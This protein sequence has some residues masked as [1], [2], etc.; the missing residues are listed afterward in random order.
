[1]NQ[2][3]APVTTKGRKMIW[4]L[5]A[6]MTM[7]TWGLYGAYLH[8]GALAFGGEGARMKAFFFVGVAY[9]LVAIIAPAA[10]LAFTKDGFNFFETPNGLKLSLFA[11]ILGAIGAFTALMALNTHPIKGPAAPA[12][13]MSVIFAGAPVVSAGYAFFMSEKSFSE[14]DWRFLLGLVMAA[15]GGALV[16]LFKP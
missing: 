8:K 14:L 15:T 1:M 11:G 3:A 4:L 7:V 12:Q 5:F 6:A 9:V 13:V 2:P 10:M 16:T